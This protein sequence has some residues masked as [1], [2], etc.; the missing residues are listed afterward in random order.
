MPSFNGRESTT[1]TENDASGSFSLMVDHA[2]SKTRS[3]TDDL[4]LSIKTPVTFRVAV[5]FDPP[6]VSDN[7]VS[8]LDLFARSIGN[9]LVCQV[10]PRL[11]IRVDGVD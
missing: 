1:T 4:V 2:S 6:R 10:D 7:R 11:E 5:D 3:T 9:N 8:R